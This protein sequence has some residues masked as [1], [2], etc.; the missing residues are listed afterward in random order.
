MSGAGRGRVSNCELTIQWQ[1]A[2]SV[3]PLKSRPSTPKVRAENIDV[4]MVLR[5]ARAEKEDKHA[6]SRRDKFATAFSSPNGLMAEVGEIGRWRASR[7]SMQAR[8]RR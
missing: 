5:N 3:S 8:S 6:R 1:S 7:R 2:F 4:R